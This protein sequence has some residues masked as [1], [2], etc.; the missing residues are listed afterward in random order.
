MVSKDLGK[1]VSKDLGKEVSKDLGKEVSKDLGKEVS[2]DLGPDSQR[3][4]TFPC[5][6]RYPTQ[7]PISH[8]F[9][10]KYLFILY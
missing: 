8:S 10:D 5:I 7:F 9:P 3:T 1:E 6:S 2:K 4:F